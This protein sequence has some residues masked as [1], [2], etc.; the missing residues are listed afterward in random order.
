[1]QMQLAAVNLA[2]P[3]EDLLCGAVGWRGA[4]ARAARG[5]QRRNEPHVMS[6][7]R[8]YRHVH[9]VRTCSRYMY[10]YLSIGTT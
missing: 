6:S 8:D 3:G 2:A 10:M 4:R 5:G 1:M 9:V 7:G